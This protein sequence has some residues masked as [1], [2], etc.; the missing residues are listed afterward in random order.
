M[1]ILSC[2]R[3]LGYVTVVYSIPLLQYETVSVLSPSPN[4]RFRV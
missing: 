2:N 4:M 3:A 1:H